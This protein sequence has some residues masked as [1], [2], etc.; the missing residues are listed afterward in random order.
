MAKVNE[1]DPNVVNKITSG[2]RING[3]IIASGDIR[4]DGS[5]K[6]N[7]NTKG[8][9][10]VGNE[11]RIVGEIICKNADISGKINGKIQV[12]ELLSLDKTADIQGEISTNKL[13]I[14]PGA[15]FT[16]SCTMKQNDSFK[17]EEKASQTEF[18]K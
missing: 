12:T 2:T 17:V 4:I 18:K 5:L 14:E 16:G 8:K 13:A 11:G 9:V 10:V 15:T 6:G 7:L 3:D 1:I